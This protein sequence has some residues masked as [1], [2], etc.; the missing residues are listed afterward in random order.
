M[1]VAVPGLQAV[2]G[3]GAGGLV[4]ARELLREGHQV[5]VFEKGS[6]VGGVWVYTDDVESDPLGEGRKGLKMSPDAAGFWIGGRFFL[7]RGL[8]GLL[9]LHSFNHCLCWLEAGRQLTQHSPG[10]CVHLCPCMLA[11]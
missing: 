1:K 5:T 6:T 8:A 9:P 11:P 10:R 2:L 7:V 3:A 4:A